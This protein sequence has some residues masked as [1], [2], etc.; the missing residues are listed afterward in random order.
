MRLLPILLLVAFHLG[1]A[2]QSS[3]WERDTVDHQIS[4]LC[5]Q[6]N[7]DDWPGQDDC[8]GLQRQALQALR[9][10]RHDDE[11]LA[12]YQFCKEA[13][14]SE[15]DFAAIQQCYKGKSSIIVANRAA[16]AMIAEKN[17]LASMFPNLPVIVQCS[18][19]DG[20]LV[21]IRRSSKHQDAIVAKVSPETLFAGR[22]GVGYSY[23]WGGAQGI[24]FKLDGNQLMDRS[25]GPVRLF[26]G[27]CEYR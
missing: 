17:E 8:I 6:R 2:T 15:Y 19:S 24:D 7:V 20:R 4:R 18:F 22:S 5:E 13:A 3:A 12:A 1:T 23:E 11:L 16:S 14:A 21:E 10:P 25:G 26:M 27:K 9:P